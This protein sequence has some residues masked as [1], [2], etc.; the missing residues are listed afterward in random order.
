[1]KYIL[2]FNLFI[3]ALFSY[4]QT[5]QI[6]KIVVDKNTKIPL[7]NVLVFNE[8][9]NSI[10]NADGKFIFV[11]QKNEINLNLL[12]YERLKTTFEELKNT[13][14][15]IFMQL[16]AIQLQEVVV[17]NTSSF[18]KKVYEKSKDN[19]LQDLQVNFFLRSV[20]KKDNITCALQD[21]SGIRNINTANQ[22][23]TGIE[24]LNMR[25][26]KIFEIKDQ[27]NFQFPAFNTVFNIV[28]PQ[29]ENCSFV[30]VPFSDSDFKKILFETN[31]KD[32]LGQI[33]KGYFIVNRNDYAIVEYNLIWI[34]DPGK[35][36]Y[37]KKEDSKKQYRTIK[38]N[39]LVKCT[40]DLVS[41]KYYPSNSQLEAKVEELIDGKARYFECNLNYFV[42]KTTNDKDIR[43]NFPADKDIFKAKFPYSKD[44][45][46]NQNQ[47]PLTK[48]LELFLKS[49][50]EKKDKTKE[51]EVIGNF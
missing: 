25:K 36:P 49:V 15:T 46:N 35:V 20:L 32:K 24:I 47:L 22:K 10:T 18:M 26:I 37:S 39:R 45:W 43:P 2:A 16:K 17:S 27:V 34:S 51:Y 29:L 30:E 9:D 13:N 21:I 11:S 40:K 3:I 48:D 1:M 5:Y 4:S 23:I 7:E 41:N 28:T 42:T 31:E 19:F 14:D 33:W 44:F 38:W 50:A 12:G 6:N 8:T